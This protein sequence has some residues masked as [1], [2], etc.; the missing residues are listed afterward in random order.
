MVLVKK[1][2]CIS[3]RT[4]TQI[5]AWLDIIGMLIALTLVGIKLGTLIF[6]IKNGE[7]ENEDEKDLYIR[8]IGKHHLKTINTLFVKKSDYATFLL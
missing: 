8:S 4:T 7:F 5:V 2:F 3:L 6:I 1:F